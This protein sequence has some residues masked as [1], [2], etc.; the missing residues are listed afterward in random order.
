M[1][2]FQSEANKSQKKLMLQG[3]NE[4][5]LNSTIAIMTVCDYNYNWNDKNNE[6]Y[7]IS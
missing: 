6:Q 3:N 5:R 4:S 7:S 1:R 2:T